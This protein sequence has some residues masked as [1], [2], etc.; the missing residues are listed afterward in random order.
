MNLVIKCAAAVRAWCAA[1][2]KR[3]AITARRHWLIVCLLVIGAALRIAVQVAYWP[4]LLYIDSVRYLFAESNWDPLGYL[5]LLWPL[6]RISGLALVAAAQHVLGLAMAGGIYAIAVRRGAKRWVGALAAVPVLFDAYQLQLEQNIM[7]DTLFEAL[8]VA[9]LAILLWNKRPG[10]RAIA[11]AGLVFGVCATVREVG[12]VLIVP[13]A[14]FVWL[15]VRG[16][17]HRARYPALLCAT[18]ALPVVG[19]VLMNFA[20]TGR[21]ELSGQGTNLYGRAAAAANCATLRIP[22]DEA[23]LCPDPGQARRLGVDGLIH[24]PS[25]PAFTLKAPSGTSSRAL[26]GDFTRRVFVQQPLAV[27]MAVARAA[28]DSFSYPRGATLADTPLFRWQ[29]QTTYPAFPPELPLTRD[30]DIIRQFGGGKPA[31]VRPVAVALRAYQLDGGYTPGPLLALC[32]F[33]AL[34]GAAGADRVWR[35]RRRAGP[36]GRP[37]GTPRR[38]GTEGHSLSGNRWPATP[39]SRADAPPEPY[40]VGLRAASFLVAA[41]GMLVLLS[42]DIIELSW[43]YQLPGLV[44]LPLAGALGVTALTS[45]RRTAPASAPRRPVRAPDPVR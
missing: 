32:G 4:A 17:R 22:A 41:S 31:V 7:A 19:Y 11:L 28:V 14:G 5:I 9:G 30:A 20:A 18:F 13:A 26:R 21:T 16:W 44:T 37:P 12:L 29:F 25:S 8:I 42:A 34:A 33:I 15:A 3:A 35:R 38:A 43:R 2:I 36:G 6:T 23:P 27:A 10:P 40:P 24:S 45:R 39:R 1:A